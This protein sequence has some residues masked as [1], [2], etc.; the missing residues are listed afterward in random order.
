MFTHTS[1][2]SLQGMTA[3]DIDVQICISSGIP[4]F[5]IVG[6]PDK[7]VGE[8][9]ERIRAAMNAI[10]LSIPPKRIT[11]NLSPADL[12]KEGSHYDLAIIL[13]ILTIM[14]NISCSNI[15]EYIAMGEL[16]LDGIIMPVSGVLPAATFAHHNNKGII[17]AQKNASEAL[18]S[19]C[20]TILAPHSLLDI[21]GHF[22]GKKLLDKP[23][24]ELEQE[25]SSIIDMKDVKGQ[26]IAKQ[27]L[28]VA[29]AGRHN[30]LCLAPLALVNQC[31][32]NVCLDYCQY[33]HH[34]KFWKLI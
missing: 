8:S 10:G 11:V 17:C 2:I 18:L 25:E 14:K 4:A 5:N 7:A 22:N 29:A 28:I 26:E 15:S 3:I 27:G 16:S 21:I 33:L 6:L 13:G 19:E 23:T 31:W 30:I 24:Q 32:Q 34:K 12:I 1:T 20:E 9:R